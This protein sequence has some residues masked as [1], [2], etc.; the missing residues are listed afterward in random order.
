MEFIYALAP[1]ENITNDSFRT[2]T[3]KYGA[4]VTFT[5]MVMIKALSNNNKSSLSRIKI[6]N[7]VPTIIQLVGLN[8]NQLEK[9]L[10][11][12]TPEPGFLGFD[13]N[14]GCPAASVV[15]HGMGCAMIKRVSKVAKLV[16]LVKDKGYKISVKMRLG[17]NKFEKDKK[18]Y[19][20]LIKRVPADYFIVHARH[21]KETFNEPADWSIFRECCQTGKNIIA[22]GDIKTKEDVAQLTSYG[23]KGVMIGRA[24]IKNPAIFDILKGK[25]VPHIAEIRKELK[26]L[27]EDKTVAKNILRQMK[28]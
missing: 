9:F 10:E 17:A 4:D 24:A 3:H 14:I 12:F 28:G 16:L 11:K 20:N 1:M 19:L 27:I 13:L 26:E 25:E 6:T 2:L 18:A 21:G 7:N 8:E 5:E 15:N 22:N 23:V